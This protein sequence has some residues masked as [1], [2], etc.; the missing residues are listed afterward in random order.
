VMGVGSGGT[1]TGIGR[2]FRA[3][4][5]HTQMVRADPEGSILAPLVL[6]GERI[7]PGSWAVEGIGEDFVP[8][9]CDLS[10]LSGA[11]TIPDEESFATARELLMKEGILGG[12]SSGTLLAAA[13]RYCRE[14][15]QAKRVVTF[16]CDSGAKYLS[17][18]YNDAWLVEEGLIARN[19]SGRVRDIV[20]RRHDEGATVTVKREETLRTAFARMKAS[21]VSQLPVVEG[22]RA[23]GLLDE[24][25]LLQ[26]LLL[27][28][29]A[30]GGGFGRTVGDV[31]IDALETVPADA[32]IETL[33]PLFE[34]GLVAIVVEGD[35]FLGLVTRADLINHL[36]RGSLQ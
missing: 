29:A 12:S 28:Q 35:R 30:T 33:I 15:T 32:A 27:G 17:K 36:R 20:V 8:P 26:A 25:D 21:D 14:Q 18:V 3:H 19:R 16:V 1:L 11:Y 7:E 34:R 6:R 24:T 10:Y 31:M 4:S 22:G 13:L 5:A 23:V 9:N 2:Y